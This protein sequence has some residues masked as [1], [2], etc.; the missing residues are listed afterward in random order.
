M[1]FRTVPGAIILLLFGLGGI[2]TGILFERIGVDWHRRSLMVGGWLLIAGFWIST[3]GTRLGEARPFLGVTA[4][5]AAGI[6]VYVS[7][8]VRRD[9]PPT[10]RL[11]LAFLGMGSI[12]VPFQFVE[13]IYRTVV[14]I[15]TVSTSVG[16]ASLGY[17]SSIEYGFEG[18]RNF[19]FVASGPGQEPVTMGIASACTG[20]SAI[21]LFAGLIAAAECSHR[22][23]IAGILVFVPSI[24]GLNVVRNVFTIVAYRNHTFEFLL[25]L[26]PSAFSVSNS[27]VFSYYV[28][29]QVIAPVYIVVGTLVVYR[30]LVA[31][32]PSIGRAIDEVVGA[33]EEDVRRVQKRRRIS[34][35]QEANQ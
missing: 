16:L 5:I 22:R 28:A 30:V 4:A 6:S 3:A 1:V 31:Q 11:S 2:A 34:D 19:I 13:P 35:R 18:H 12:Y 24:F 8:L 25:A 33:M 17:Y 21:A 7:I 26:A 32:F 23:K 15:V 9:S 10:R 27:N 20:I 29:E 14:E